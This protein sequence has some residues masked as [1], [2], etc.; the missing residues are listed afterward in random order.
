MK[1]FEV[2]LTDRERK[3]EEVALKWLETK[4]KGKWDYEVKLRTH[5]ER[6]TA[7]DALL[8]L[9]EYRR[10]ENPFRK[11]SMEEAAITATKAL[12]EAIDAFNAARAAIDEE[13][14]QKLEEKREELYRAAL[15]YEREI[16]PRMEELVKLYR[17]ILA[18]QEKWQAPMVHRG[19]GIAMRNMRDLLKSGELVHSADM[20]KLFKEK[21]ITR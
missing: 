11:K 20:F 18:A 3:N 13:K 2:T 5:Q 4:V 16:V 21:R 7:F 12:H 8:F 15:A 14:R 10:E 6:K 1:I 17:P 19:I 9:D